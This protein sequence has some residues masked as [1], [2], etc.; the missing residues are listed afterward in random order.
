MKLFSFLLLFISFALVGFGLMYPKNPIDHKLKKRVEKRVFNCA[1]FQENEFSKQLN[2]YLGQYI[3]QS[4]K[5]GVPASEE[6]SGIDS[7]LKTGKLKSVSNNLGFE[8]EKFRYSY[9]VL[10]PYAEKIL[11]EIGVAF[12]DSLS[13]TPLAN[14]KLLVTSM[15][16]THTTVNRLM[17]RNRTAVKR[18]PHLNGNSFDFSF[19]RFIS[20]RKIT[21]CERQYLQELSASILLQFKKERKIWVTFERHEECLHVVTRMGK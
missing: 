14:T 11:K 20:E 5:E 7:Y 13:H 18:S 4:S 10:T 15:T 1:Q 2:N 19:S 21:D 9:A 6:K 12:D 8:L 3:D 16:R 17:R